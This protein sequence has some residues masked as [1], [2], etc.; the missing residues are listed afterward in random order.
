MKRK[1]VGL[2]ASASALALLSVLGCKQHST[3][4]LTEIALPGDT[5][6]PE[7]ITATADGTL[8]VGNFSDGGVLRIKPGQ[9]PEAWIKPAVFGTRSVLGLLVD[10]R[11]GMLWLCS[12]DLTVLGVAGPSEEKGALLKG[13]DLK[14]GEGKVSAALPG[15]PSLCNDIAVDDAGGVYATNTLQPE[16]L[17]LSADRK[18]LEVWKHDDLLAP[19]ATG[20]GGLDGIAFGSDGN[21]LVNTFGGGELFRIAVKDGV[22]GDVT[23]LKT[24]RALKFPDVIRK[25]GANQFLMIEG[26]GSLDLVKIDGDNASISTIKDGYSGPTGVVQIGDTGWISEGQ[27]PHLLDPSLKG[28]SPRLPFKVYS[29]ALPKP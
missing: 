13:F 21:M 20:G 29:V 17:K 15:E 22:A 10:E 27:L 5:A 4:A 25:F 3:P 6:Y 8:Y 18:T 12:N 19:P 26:A 24:S 7:N 28:K 11:A 9:A 23:R 14:T 16:V 1:S 2:A